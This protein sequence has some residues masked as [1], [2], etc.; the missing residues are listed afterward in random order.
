MDAGATR[1][2]AAGRSRDEG[3]ITL[4][5]SITQ[6][7]DRIHSTYDSWWILY[8]LAL[9]R[10]RCSETLKGIVDCLNPN[11]R[12]RM[13]IEDLSKWDDIEQAILSGEIMT[14]SDF[15]KRVRSISEDT[16]FF[17]ILTQQDETIRQYCESY[18]RR[19]R[20]QRLYI[21]GKTLRDLCVPEGPML[22]RILEEVL[23]KKIDGEVETEEEERRAASEI[24]SRLSTART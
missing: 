9:F 14:A 4:I 13:A 15:Y 16:V 6:A 12:L 20:H 21:D 11:R 22:G 5:D 24:W 8:L 7:K 19:H 10:P 3:L 18:Y 2:N 23:F 17:K 1:G